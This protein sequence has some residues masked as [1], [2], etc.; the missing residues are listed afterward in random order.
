MHAGVRGPRLELRSIL[1]LHCDG[2]RSLEIRAAATW[3]VS[4]SSTLRNAGRYIL[5]FYWQRRRSLNFENGHALIHGLIFGPRYVWHRP[6]DKPSFVDIPS[7]TFGLS[8]LLL[9]SRLLCALSSASTSTLTSDSGLEGLDSALTA[10]KQNQHAHMR[11]NI[12]RYSQP[13]PAYYFSIAALELIR[14]RWEFLSFG[15]RNPPLSTYSKANLRR[16]C[17]SDQKYFIRL[18]WNGSKSS[19][20]VFDDCACACGWI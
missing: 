18:L 17:I 20:L 12:L 2:Y 14:G 16:C 19:L 10:P 6:G 7:S 11:L 15:Q 13:A 9:Y 3:L 4:C 1:E 8:M 5:A